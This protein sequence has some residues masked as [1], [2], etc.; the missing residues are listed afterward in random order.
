MA[1]RLGAEKVMGG[2]GINLQVTKRGIRCQ[3]HATK[4]PA[5]PRRTAPAREAI[6]QPRSAD[7]QSIRM[8]PLARHPGMLCRQRAA[9][10]DPG[11]ACVELQCDAGAATEIRM[12]PDTGRCRIAVAIR[13]AYDDAK[14][15]VRQRVGQ[16]GIERKWPR[17]SLVP[18][19]VVAQRQAS[20]QVR[21][22]TDAPWPLP[23]DAVNG[24]RMVTEITR[25][26]IRPALPGEAAEG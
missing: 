14:L 6:V 19:R 3:R 17:A 13:H 20:R 22:G 7:R 15:R 21:D 11:A 8:V 4:D 10:I 1:H 16:G 25:Q 5:D 12:Q 26:L 23:T 18:G 2:W 9:A 24:M